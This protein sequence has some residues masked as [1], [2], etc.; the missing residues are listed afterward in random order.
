MKKYKC[1]YKHSCAHKVEE[2]E[3]Q[4]SPVERGVMHDVDKKRFITNFDIKDYAQYCE[5]IDKWDRGHLLEV[6]YIDCWGSKQRGLGSLYSSDEKK[7][8]TLFWRLFD[9]LESA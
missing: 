9:S 7:D 4:A 1:N 5:A 3:R 2:I 8:L 6:K